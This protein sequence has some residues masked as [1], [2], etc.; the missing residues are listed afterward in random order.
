ME[1]SKMDLKPGPGLVSV[2]HAPAARVVLLLVAVVLTTGIMG[3]AALADQT[4]YYC[5]QNEHTVKYET[6]R[7]GPTHF[8]ACVSALKAWIE[9]EDPLNTA[10]IFKHPSV[11]V[12]LDPGVLCTLHL[13][14]A[15]QTAG[16]DYCYY[17]W[18]WQT[19]GAFFSWSFERMDFSS[20]GVCSDSQI[21]DAEGGCGCP[22]NQVQKRGQC[23]VAQSCSG[24]GNPCDAATGNKS[25]VETDYASGGA[26]IG[27]IRAY[28]S[29]QPGDFGF[30]VG[31]TAS[32][33][34]QLIINV[35]DLLI[36]RGDGW[37]DPFSRQGGLWQGDA[38]TDFS[39][40]EDAGGFNIR[41]SNG[42][43]ER[44][45]LGGK[46]LSESSVAGLNITYR[47]DAEGLL[48]KITG[49]YG[50]VMSLAH[51]ISGHIS[52]ITDPGNRVYSYTY[53]SDGNLAAVQYPD[54]STRVY[55]YENLNF[56]NHLTGITDGNGERF[57]TY[58]YGNDGRAILTEHTQTTNASPQE[59][60]LFDYT[61]PNATVVTDPIGELWDYSYQQNLGLLQLVS[62]FSRSDGKGVRQ[63]YDAN[64]NLVVR[65]DEEGR[66]INHAYNTTNQ[67][68]TTTVAVGSA[69]E[70]TTFYEYVTPDTYLPTRVASP[71]IYPGSFREVVT[72]YDAD[73]NISAMEVRGFDPMGNPLS[74]IT[75]FAYN[76]RGQVTRIDGPRTDISDITTIT[77]YECAT[78]AECGQ[79][80]SRINALGQAITF[81]AY[82]KHGRLTR[83]T[84]LVG[85][86]TER[87]Y[88]A[89]D[90]MT[91]ITQTASAGRAR[92][93]TLGYDSEGQLKSLVTPDGITLSYTYDAAHNL[94]SVNDIMGN[95]VEYTYDPKGN[96]TREVVRDPDGQLVRSV[97]TAYDLRDHVQSIDTAG[98][99]TRNLR[100][101]VGNLISETDP[102]LN[103]GTTHGYDSVGRLIR[104]LDALANP[105]AFQYDVRD[106]I[107]E[108][109]A[110]NG[111]VTS[112]E[113]DDLGNLLKETSPDRGEV[114]YTYDAAGNVIG[115]T[116][117]RNIM[118]TY[119]YDALNRATNIDYPGTVHDQFIVY[120]TCAQ[121]I[122]RLCSSTD[123]AGVTSLEYDNFGNVLSQTR[124]E[125]GQSFIIRY[126]YDDGDR[127][128]QITYPHGGVVV[129]NRDAIGR[130]TDVNFHLEGQSVPIISQ[131]RYRADGLVTSQTAGNGL[132][133]SRQFDLQGRLIS[134]NLGTIDSRAY[135]YDANGNQL[136]RD[137]VTL[138][139]P[140]PVTAM[141]TY[142]VL[143]RITAD[144]GPNGTFGFTYDVN[145]NRLSHTKDGK[146]RGYQYEV[147]SNR[148]VE[149]NGKAVIL[150]AAGNTI[151]DRNSKRVFEYDVTGRL[152]KFRKN[153][154]LKATY[155]YNAQGQ[156]TRKTVATANGQRTFIYHYDLTGNL[157]AETRNGKALRY[158][159]WADSQP[160]AQI[161]LRQ[162]STGGVSVRH[163]T[164]ITT[165]HLLTPRLG[166]DETQTI[167]W[168][169]DGDTFGQ[170]R[171]DKDPDDDE[172]N[173]N[174][175][176]RFPG[177]FHDGESGLYYNWNRYYD[178]KTGRYI[179]SDPIGLGG[180]L[181]TYGY[182]GGNPLRYIDLA[183]LLI[184]GRVTDIGIG[185]V[186]MPSFDG[187]YWISPSIPDS[188][189]GN[190][191]AKYRYVGDALAHFE[192]ECKDTGQCS[193]NR[194]WSLYRNYTFTDIPTPWFYLY[195]D[196]PTIIQD[197]ILE[198]NA[199]YTSLAT[200]RRVAGG[201][202]RTKFSDAY[203]TLMCIANRSGDQNPDPGPVLF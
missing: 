130:I 197:I 112:Y 59:R 48:T 51:D 96:R 167:V 119:I 190:R 68:L 196:E 176:L 76:E 61:G 2:T 38:D 18:F 154:A 194:E 147:P 108:V 89:R 6:G 160:L 5:I 110:P 85:V 109:T 162:T 124:V 74:R 146:I 26:G 28:N 132:I 179:T 3:R 187:F 158:Y 55:H 181:N 139:D 113:Y 83:S 25:Q 67:K 56:P 95:R 46:L 175:R 145:S 11:H 131:R 84:D 87:A 64:N 149:T 15:Q 120:D 182:V 58:A 102:N 1:V 16:R 195:N 144:S 168:R 140:A 125:D 156:R 75:T 78:G 143:N 150:D 65:T 111:A 47:Y 170:T 192:I 115:I 152:E 29:A 193:N 91:R 186:S 171:A 92:I 163:T 106:N 199:L 44:Y 184:T 101:A 60:Y 153:G 104:T 202:A 33:S 54:G 183:G 138:T 12:P 97:Q 52:S 117:A 126:Q 173:R 200:I 129:Y 169:W 14:D 93:T 122:G 136:T 134:Q 31:W 50:H 123:E 135:Q 34:K 36:Q 98:S 198:L 8:D 17:D 128:E 165:D 19:S 71:S 22:V 63:K 41:L 177:Q 151:S 172:E 159:L 7:Y 42:D 40:V 99:I 21:I 57:A 77:Y 24:V 45:D 73:F 148:A 66:T 116:D 114:S 49:P 53:D 82:D 133:E 127:I 20:S 166:T 30:G 137:Q 23:V 178:P 161:R 189:R 100:D 155:F 62:R 142:D 4:L 43:T 13:A 191:Y 35:D 107:S 10:F 39:V 86:V 32:F 80:A 201:I 103:P 9:V 105:T 94:R 185:F 88:D 70:R 121:G 69:Q 79:P 188:K 180:G 118:V 72:T 37:Q 174:I 90:R 141:Y 164:Y 81:D 27:L 157:I 203:A